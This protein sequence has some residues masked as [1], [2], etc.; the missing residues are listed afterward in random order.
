MLEKELLLSIKDTQQDF[1]LFYDLDLEVLSKNNI[2]RLQEHIKK[3]IEGQPPLTEERLPS[4]L[5][6]QEAR[7]MQYILENSQFTH[8]TA[9]LANI[10]DNDNTMKSLQERA[11]AREQTQNR[12]TKAGSKTDGYL[13]FTFGQ[14]IPRFL[15]AKP[16][17]KITFNPNILQNLNKATY[18]HAFISWYP[19]AGLQRRT[20][21]IYYLDNCRFHYTH[22]SDTKKLYIYHHEDQK[23]IH[24][25]AT[26]SQEIFYGEDILR[27]L[28]YQMIL[29]L[30]LIGGSYRQ[31]VLNHFDDNNVL[32]AFQE[33]IYPVDYYP[34][35][36]L[37][38]QFNIENSGVMVTEAK[39]IDTEH[40]SFIDEFRMIHL[41]ER[42]AGSFS[43]SYLDEKD[44][45]YE[46]PSNAKT[47]YQ[48]KILLIACVQNGNLNQAE[49][50]ISHNKF[51]LNEE[52]PIDTLLNTAIKDI[53][54]PEQRMSMVKL[55]I[56]Y[57]ADP[58]RNKD[59]GNNSFYYAVKKKDKTLFGYLLT[60][61]H[62]HPLDVH[63][64][65]GPFLHQDKQLLSDKN[66]LDLIC[67][68]NLMDWLPLA[69]QY[70]ANIHHFP[71]LLYAIAA[72]AGH[73]DVVAALIHHGVS[74]ED[75]LVNV[76]T[77]L[78]IFAEQGNEEG[79][80]LLLQHEVDIHHRCYFDKKYVNAL[81]L[82]L[83]SKK[84][85]EN[86]IRLLREKGLIETAS[87]PSKNQKR[88]VAIIVTAE[89]QDGDRYVLLGQ[90]K[91]KDNTIDDEYCFPGGLVEIRD[92][93]FIETAM[94]EL[95]E[96][97]NIKLRGSQLK[98][99][100]SQ[101][102]AFTFSEVYQD[103]YFHIQFIHFHLFVNPHTIRIKPDD[104][105]GAVSWL[106][107]SS[108]YVGYDKFEMK[109][110]LIKERETYTLIKQSNGLVLDSLFRTNL[111]IKAMK[112]ALRIDNFGEYLLIDA[113]KC[114]DV[115]E[116]KDLLHHRANYLFSL[117]DI[118]TP[119][120]L[121][122]ASGSMNAVKFYLKFDLN[123][124]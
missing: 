18:Q 91:N 121:A 119:L 83:K 17:D 3:G 19:C 40:P 71:C 27:G 77:P 64:Q 101:H 124:T 5:T 61:K 111:D 84:P 86:I 102:T 105:M 66:I 41:K 13:Y 92:Q 52:Y 110:F 117:E 29:H 103:T 112:K 47:D 33:M 12:N 57:G 8:N 95:E 60:I 46:N 80:K 114:D 51:D 59:S 89:E 69:I 23:P 68:N 36:K 93:D 100:F 50:L 81:D 7:F 9:S 22:V 30:R 79:V 34:E 21:P 37:P 56:Q 76:K 49:S 32:T 14:T 38:V 72:K 25:V 45:L 20:T 58:S 75:V 97:T 118:G 96:E 67:E 35:F 2:Q 42:M 55:L 116:I 44:K 115:A 106:P 15:S 11:A 53:E 16:Q 4:G 122:A 73:V 98:G 62:P 39:F 94:R 99:K 74:L 113:T 24:F 31:H 43:F 107:L 1:E 78:M 88:A 85:N 28:A 120:N 6:V 109:R 82:A 90:K 65:K 10:K 87:P 48:K 108:V 70:G 123:Y 54:N 104:D 26:A 63:I